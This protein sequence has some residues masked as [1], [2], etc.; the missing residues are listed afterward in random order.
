[1]M[2]LLA[3]IRHPSSLHVGRVPS[4]I[5]VGYKPQTISNGVQNQRLNVNQLT[6]G[7]KGSTTVWQETPG[8]PKARLAQ[9]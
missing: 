2:I 7:P 9:K 5:L 3:Q 1:M 6:V 8:H 4:P